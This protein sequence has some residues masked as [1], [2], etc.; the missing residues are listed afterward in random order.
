MGGTMTYSYL[1]DGTKVAAVV[2]LSAPA[3]TPTDNAILEQNISGMDLGL[4]DFGARCY[5]PYIARW[6]SVDPMAHKYLGLS[7]YNYCGTNPVNAIDPDGMDWYKT[8]GSIKWTDYKSQEEMA[9]NDITGT[10][11]GERVVVFNGSYDE[12]LGKGGNIY[13]EGA[14]TDTVDVYG[15]TGADDIG[16]YTGFTMTSNYKKFGAIAD[17]EYNV[18]YNPSTNTKSIVPK[19]YAVNNKNAVDCVNGINPSPKEYDPY[20]A[21]QKNG[22]YIHRTNNNG[23]AGDKPETYNCVSSD[24]LLIG[25]RDWDSFYNQIGK[26]GFKLILKRK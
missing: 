3:S 10:Y 4:L 8:E 9:Q 13:G 15:S 12:S 25:V 22:I 23:W 26:N 19:F 6:T 5:D 17:G 7:P 21:T 16:H 20:S 14:K 18:T 2:N 24:C 1:G 11:L